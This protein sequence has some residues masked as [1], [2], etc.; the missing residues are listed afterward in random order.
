MGGGGFESLRYK[1]FCFEPINILVE[2]S[3]R[4]LLICESDVTG[5][6]QSCS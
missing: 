6:D 3:N 2:I 4:Y 5:K 1:N